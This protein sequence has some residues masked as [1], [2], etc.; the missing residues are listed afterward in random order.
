LSGSFALVM[1]VDRSF[2]SI[3][4]GNMSA[5]SGTELSVFTNPLRAGRNL[6]PFD[7]AAAGGAFPE[8]LSLFE[9]RHEL[10]P[11]GSQQS[12]WRERATSAVDDD[13]DSAGGYDSLLIRETEQSPD[14]LSYRES[15]TLL[16]PANLFRVVTADDPAHDPR[17]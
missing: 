14:S 3:A 11:H 17:A 10:L 7:G 9:S 1:Q 15:P 12:L 13:V 5:A 16:A 4:V 8:V 2:L 6:E